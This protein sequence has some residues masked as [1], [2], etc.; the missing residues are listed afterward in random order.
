MNAVYVRIILYVLSP[1]L[2]TLI[3]KIPGWGV[4]FSNGVLT[5]DLSTLAGVIVAALGFS[6][7]IF[8]KWGVK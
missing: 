6:G 1:I 2:T 5:I 3:A 8:A 7:A 4:G